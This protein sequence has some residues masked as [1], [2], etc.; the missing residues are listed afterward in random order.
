MKDKDKLI[1]LFNVYV[2]GIARENVF[3]ALESLAK[4]L[5]GFFDDSVK[6]IYIPTTNI[7]KPAVQAVTDFP[8]KG[9][10]LILQLGEYLKSGDEESLKEQIETLCEFAKLYEEGQIEEDEEL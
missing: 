4:S 10:E 6:T 3:Y 9:T 5:E 8:W 1:L 2:G 7:D